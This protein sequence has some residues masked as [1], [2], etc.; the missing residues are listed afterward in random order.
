MLKVLEDFKDIMD[1]Y[2]TVKDTQDYGGNPFAKIMRHE[3]ADDLYDL[4]SKYVNNSEDYKVKYFTGM[5]KW[6]NDPW[7]SIMHT[8][9]TTTA[10]KGFYVGILFNLN[11]RKLRIHLDQAFEESNPEVLNYRSEVLSSKIK[12]NNCFKHYPEDRHIIV[13]DYSF[14]DIDDETFINDFKYLVETYEYLIPFYEKLKEEPQETVY[15]PQNVWKVTPGEKEIFEGCWND[16]LE[17]GYTAIGWFCNKDKNVDYNSLKGEDEEKTKQNIQKQLVK[18]YKDKH[19]PLKVKSIYDFAFGMKKGD[20]VVSNQGYFNIL[21]IGV[22]TSDYISPDNPENPS[23]NCEMCH[24]RKVNWIYKKQVHSENQIFDQ[25]T[26]TPLKIEKWEEILHIYFKDNIKILLN[27]LYSSFKIEYLETDKGREHYKHYESEKEVLKKNLD[28]ILSIKNDE[29]KVYKRVCRDLIAALPYPTIFDGYKQGEGAEKVLRNGKGNK[30]SEE[31][32][33][34]MSKDFLDLLQNLNNEDVSENDKAIVDFANKGYKGLQAGVISPALYLS[35]SNYLF[36]NHK[37]YSTCKFLGNLIGYSINLNTS[38][39]SY[40]KTNNE[41]KL[42]LTEILKY[43]PEFED[44]KKFDIFCHWCVDKNLGNYAGEDARFLP[45]IKNNFFEDDGEDMNE[46]NMSVKD[47]KENVELDVDENLFSKLAASL[48]SGNHI[49]MDGVPGTGKTE[50]AIGLCEVAKS[51]CFIN[52]YILTTATSDWTTFDTIG[53]LMPDSKG[54]LFFKEGKF[55][56]SIRDNDWLIIDE[57]NRSDIDK[58]FGQLFT[59]LSGQNVELPYEINGKSIKIIRDKTKNISRFDENTNTY[60]V[61]NNWR[62]IATMN[63]YD[64]DYLYDLSYAFMRR[65]MFI[66]VGLPKDEEYKMLISKWCNGLDSYYKNNL[67]KLLDINESRE[68]GPAIF[69]DMIDYIKSANEVYDENTSSL[70]EPIE[71]T[72]LREAVL[73][74]IVPQFEGLTNKQIEDIQ[75]IIEPIFEQNIIYNKLESFKVTGL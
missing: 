20:I 44:Y 69:K 62:I 22:V 11:E 26:V 24:V 58:A 7:A 30:Y 40:I 3:Y 4:T 71:K 31:K 8:D 57:I 34:N 25:K 15:W 72:I 9:I 73:S 18:W 10:K 55:L 61:G 65:F 14:D 37:V 75:G 36:I 33:I 2:Q 13:K 38:L 46:V 59:V 5:G 45:I 70:N 47:I 53:G 21:G 52:D 6:V 42:F 67:I 17:N 29:T 43:I 39:K 50:L 16:F 12:I 63:V 41:Y 27:Y 54:E 32:F 35:N 49:I 48:N 60:I 66:N 19:A 23:K 1:N 51:K 56:Q 68:L 64:K 28:E 74:Y